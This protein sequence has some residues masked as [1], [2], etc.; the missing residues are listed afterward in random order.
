MPVSDPDQVASQDVAVA[1]GVV[2]PV[3]R[4]LG[5]S[6][7][8]GAA[9]GA[10]EGDGWAG[11]GVAGGAPVFC[12]GELGDAAAVAVGVG[13]ADGPGAGVVLGAGVDP[14]VDPPLP[15]DGLDPPPA[16]SYSRLAGGISFVAS[17]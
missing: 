7:S 6:V 17:S 14:P 11:A 9:G 12:A 3:T 2:G 13:V 1:T 15:C 16:R 5:A 10:G 4:A 8:R